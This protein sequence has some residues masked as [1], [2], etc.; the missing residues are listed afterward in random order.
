M[1]CGVWATF[2]T[3]RTNRLRPEGRPDCAL[4]CFQALA[5]G[6]GE[7]GQCD[8]QAENRR[9]SCGRLRAEQPFPVEKKRKQKHAQETAKLAH[10][11]SDAVACRSHANRKN[12]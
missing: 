7:H 5:F 2:T 10:R 12:L 3:P 4:N 6:L 8:K 1:G 11:S 9:D